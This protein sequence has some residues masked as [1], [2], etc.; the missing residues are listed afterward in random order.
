MSDI[1]GVGQGV[2]GVAQAGA[3]VAAAAINADAINNAT[4]AQRDAF[5]TITA[6]NKPFL[7]T[8]TSALNQLGAS[9]GLNGGGGAIDPNAGFYQSPDYQFRLGQG[10][11]GVDAGA[12]ARGMLDSGATRKAEIGYAGNLA[13]G[14]FNTYANRLQSLAGIGQAAASNQAGAAQGYANNIGNLAQAGANNL[15][16]GVNNLAGLFG[17][18]SQY[19]SSYSGPSSGGI[20][21]MFST[22]GTFGP[23]YTG[24]GNGEW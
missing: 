9:Y 7:T 14:E 24:D 1:F 6:N 3:T 21:G 22:G 16:N 5:N 23:A 11:K 15:S 8:G 19:G 2:S 13:S 17:G 20:N 10:I 18:K 4:D 12:A